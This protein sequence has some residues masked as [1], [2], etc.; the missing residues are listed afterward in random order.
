MS[1]KA[2]GTPET[3]FPAVSVEVPSGC[4][5]VF[6]YDCLT[7]QTILMNTWLPNAS[8]VERVA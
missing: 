3:R 1:R 8:G 5:T 4:V 7:D 2:G 6:V